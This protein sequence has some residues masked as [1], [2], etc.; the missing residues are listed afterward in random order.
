MT[1]KDGTVQLSNY[2]NNLNSPTDADKKHAILSS[3]KKIAN[4]SYTVGISPSRKCNQLGQWE[5]VTNSCERI[6]CPALD[7]ELPSDAGAYNLDDVITRYSESG[8]VGI[9]STSSSPLVSSPSDKI[10]F[11]AP[12]NSSAPQ[13]KV[14]P[15]STNTEY[16]LLTSNGANINL[17]KDQIYVFEYKAPNYYQLDSSKDSVLKELWKRSGGASFPEGYAIRS[18]N[19]YYMPNSLDLNDQHLVSGECNSQL[20]YISL[21][22]KPTMLCDSLG[23]WTN[24]NNSCVGDCSAVNSVIGND[25]THG[26]AIWQKQSPRVGESVSSSA[27]SCISGTFAYPYSP[28]NDDEGNKKDYGINNINLDITT[29]SYDAIATTTNGADFTIPAGTLPAPS[30]K[31]LQGKS[32]ALK[33]Q[34]NFGSSSAF[35]DSSSGDKIITIF[36][37]SAHTIDAPTDRVWSRINF[38]SYGTPDYSSENNLQQD[39]ENNC[40]FLYTKLVLA[41]KCL[42]KPTCN[43]SL[44]DFLNY[45]SYMPENCQQNFGNGLNGKISTIEEIGSTGGGGGGNSSAESGTI[46]SVTVNGVTSHSLSLSENGRSFCDQNLH[47]NLCNVTLANNGG[48]KVNITEND[49]G[50]FDGQSGYAIIK[51]APTDDTPDESKTVYNYSAP[52]VYTITVPTLAS[53]IGK[54]DIYFY[55]DYEIA[56]GGGGGGGE[57]IAQG[58]D[59]NPGS[60]VSGKFKIEAGKS[61]KVHIGG[62]GKA[63]K[64][65]CFGSSPP[66]GAVSKFEDKYLPNKKFAIAKNQ[67]F[68]KKSE[69]KTYDKIFAKNSHRQIFDD[70]VYYQYFVKSNSN[71]NYKKISKINNLRGFFKFAKYSFKSLVIKKSYAGSCNKAFDGVNYNWA[72]GQVFNYACGS[73]QYGSIKETCNCPANGFAY[74]FEHGSFNGVGVQYGIGEHDLC[75]KGYSDYFS[76]MKLYGDIRVLLNVGCDRWSNE[77]AWGYY[78]GTSG[79]NGF[80]FDNYFHRYNDKISFIGIEDIR[81]CDWTTTGSCT[82]NACGIDD[83]FGISSASSGYNASGSNTGCNKAN[84]SGTFDWYC[85]SNDGKATISRNGCSCVANYHTSGNNCVINTCTAGAAQGY[86]GTTTY[87][88]ASGTI[89]CNKTNFDTSKTLSFSACDS[90]G[91]TK[92]TTGGTCTCATGY[93]LSGSGTTATC[94]RIKCNAPAQTG[95]SGSSTIDYNTSTTAQNCNGT[96]FNTSNQITFSACTTNGSNLTVSSG[97]CGCASGYYLSGSGTTATCPRIKCNAPAQAGYSGSSTIDY[98]TSTTAQNCDGTNFNTSN[99]IIFSACTANNSN[100]TVSSGSCGC[101]S[102]YTLSGT[103]ASATC[104]QNCNRKDSSSTYT[105]TANFGFTISSTDTTVVAGNGGTTTIACS[106]TGYATGT[107]NATLTCNSGALT[108]TTSCSCASGYHKISGKCVLATCTLPAQT[109]FASETISSSSNFTSGSISKSC[110]NNYTGTLNF[111]C[112]HPPTATTQ[113][114]T[115]TSGTCTCP[116]GF[117]TSGSGVTQSCSAITCSASARSGYTGSSTI[118]YTSSNTSINCN[119]TNF[120]NTNILTYDSCNSNGKT[121]TY[122]SGTC[123]CSSGY[124]L[125]TNATPSNNSCIANC[126]LAANDITK[127]GLPSTTS[128][129]LSALSTSIACKN[130]DGYLNNNATIGCDGNTTSTS[131][132]L[133]TNCNCDTTNNFHHPGTVT[134][135]SVPTGSWDINNSCFKKCT[136]S[137]NLSEAFG[138]GTSSYDVYEGK[139]RKNCTGTRY[140]A[141]NASGGANQSSVVCTRGATVSAVGTLSI[142]SSSESCPCATG[143]T[144]VN[145]GNEHTIPTGTSFFKGNDGSCFKICSIS[146]NDSNGIG[147]GTNSYQIYEGSNSKS[148]S[149]TGFDTSS[150][151]SISCN[152]SGTA[153]VTTG[154]SCASGYSKSTSSTHTKPSDS[155]TLNYSTGTGGTCYKECVI[156]AGKAHGWGV[157][158][159]GF[160]ALQ[161]INNINCSGARY[162]T[163]ATPNVLAISCSSTGSPTISGG[164]PCATGYS[165]SNGSSG[166]T[167]PL[168]NTTAG[169][170]IEYFYLTPSQANSGTCFKDCSV[171]STQSNTWG[172]GTSAYTVYEGTNTKGCTSNGFVTGNITVNC[173]SSGNATVTTACTKV[174][175]PTSFQ[176]EGVNG[177][178]LNKT[179]QNSIS[180]DA[181]GYHGNLDFYCSNSGSVASYT[182]TTSCLEYACTSSWTPPGISTQISATTGANSLT[183]QS[184]LGYHGTY[185]Y[186]CDVFGNHQETSTCIA[187]SCNLSPDSLGGVHG[188]G[189]LARTGLSGNGS[190]DCDANGYSGTKY[191]SC[192]ASGTVT[193]TGT[194]YAN[195]CN[196]FTNPGVTGSITGKSG[197][198]SNSCTAPGY[199]G[200]LSFYCDDSNQAVILNSCTENVCDI[201]AGTGYSGKT[202][203]SI[204]GSYACD[205]GYYGTVNWVC[206]V[207]GGNATVTQNC[208]RIT[209]DLPN[210][211]YSATITHDFTDDVWTN[212]LCKRGYKRSFDPISGYFVDPQ[213]KCQRDADGANPSDVSIRNACVEVTCYIPGYGNVNYNNSNRHTITCNP[214]EGLFGTAILICDENGTITY[215]RSCDRISC[216]LPSCSGGTCPANIQNSIEDGTRIQFSNNEMILSCKESHF[217]EPCPI[218]MT[219][220]CGSPKVRCT[221]DPI[222]TTASTLGVPIFSGL[223]CQQST[224]AASNDLNSVIDSTTVNWTGATPVSTTCKNGYYSVNP[225]EPPKYT[226]IGSGTNARFTPINPCTAVTCLPGNVF[227]MNRNFQLTWGLNSVVS[228][229]KVGYSGTFEYNCTGSTTPGTFSTVR[230]NCFIRSCNL[231]SNNP[232]TFANYVVNGQNQGGDGGKISA[233]ITYLKGGNGGDSSE[234]VTSGAG[235]GGGSVSFIETLDGRIIVIAGGGGGGNGGGSDPYIIPNQSI[236]PVADTKLHANF[237]GSYLIARMQS[238]PI[239]NSDPEK[240][241]GLIYGKSDLSGRFNL[242]SPNGMFINDI[243][244]SSLGD[245]EANDPNLLNPNSV[246]TPTNIKYG[247]CDSSNSRTISET[248]CVNFESCEITDI[249]ELE[250][251]YPVCSPELTSKNLAVL[252]G[253]GFKRPGIEINGQTKLIMEINY[254]TMTYAPATLEHNKVY[255]FIDYGEFWLKHDYFGD[256]YVA[257]VAGSFDVNSSPIKIKFH[258]TNTTLDPK[259]KIVINSGSG[260]TELIPQ[261]LIKKIYN[262]KPSPI[263]VGYIKEN[264]F[265]ILR[266]NQENLDNQFWEIREFSE[267]SALRNTANELPKRTCMTTQLSENGMLGTVWSPS[268]SYCTNKCPGFNP[269]TK[270]GDDRIGAGA[271]LHYTSDNRNG[272]IVYWD[273]AS[274]GETRILTLST[275]ANPET[276]KLLNKGYP[277]FPR[278]LGSNNAKQFEKENGAQAGSEVFILER[279]CGANGVWSDPKPLCFT[280]GGTETNNPIGNFNNT[281]VYLN[282]SSHLEGSVYNNSAQNKRYIQADQGNASTAIGEC[283]SGYSRITKLTNGLY[284]TTGNIETQLEPKLTFSCHSSSLSVN[285]NQRRMEDLTYLDTL[286]GSD[287]R[288]YCKMSDLVIEA[289]SGIS[290]AGS[291]NL[292]NANTLLIPGKSI[293]LDCKTGFTYTQSYIRPNYLLN[294]INRINKN[295]TINWDTCQMASNGDLKNLRTTKL[296]TD[297]R[298]TD[299]QEKHIDCMNQIIFEWYW[300]WDS[301]TSE[302]KNVSKSGGPRYNNFIDGTQEHKTLIGYYYDFPTVHQNVRQNFDEDS[303]LIANGKTELKKVIANPIRPQ[304]ECN[305]VNSGDQRDTANWSSVDIATDCRIAD[306]CKITKYHGIRF[307]ASQKDISKIAKNRPP[308]LNDIDDRW[309]PLRSFLYT[310]EVNACGSEICLNHGTTIN[311][312]LDTTC[313]H[314]KYGR[315]G[316]TVNWKSAWNVCANQYNAMWDM[317]RKYLKSAS[318]NDGHLSVEWD[319][320]D[321]NPGKSCDGEDGYSGS[322]CD[323]VNRVEEEKKPE[324]KFL[325]YSNDMDF[326]S[327]TDTFSKMRVTTASECSPPPEDYSPPISGFGNF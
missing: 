209:C 195:T 103:G 34:Q 106:G 31:N 187:Y 43:I 53:V 262:N 243:I 87:T 229:N 315:C 327:F 112:I 137:A 316:Y 230:N 178:I 207:N 249:N 271:T 299:I 82:N 196:P 119:G 264:I 95:Y 160:N 272:G 94:E 40:H 252:A 221:F 218:N 17:A 257:T 236:S 251:G 141:T 13:I 76:S 19:Y 220:N 238:S 88:G 66:A 291:S 202:N 280:G 156:S 289:S 138:T 131:Y 148:C 200:I 295:Y 322:G 285:G 211:A 174:G 120:D 25:P 189:F 216:T 235:G 193:S 109:G 22:K 7:F 69:G 102:G 142:A 48:L 250:F 9:I 123:N 317:K 27:T 255:N 8:G 30:E 162:A 179:G 105:N 213:Y 186:Y 192:G 212:Y 70:R 108:L 269:T 52:G 287:C 274:I 305:S 85:S 172:T 135:H 28:P 46:N 55:V 157:G 304:F 247:T 42:G 118:A 113:N 154:C 116:S 101:A 10:T 12:S 171:T 165:K 301:T 60:K 26:F 318:C 232:T 93:Y 224:C 275:R 284:P 99:Q 298:P 115:F 143:F 217:F 51:V 190:V 133:T 300:D 226:C 58:T 98:N 253:Y 307:G 223:P 215:E 292:F 136:V 227:G 198:S 41:L 24:L 91:A 67:N 260:S 14:K 44:S 83:A 324:Q 296:S 45:D 188:I 276:D 205:N 270:V 72:N 297:F 2:I 169:S 145:S 77:G 266:L 125:K 132:S 64:T 75:K 100:L 180:C 201:P 214:S 97:S 314:N 286:S 144:K 265:Y 104:K 219:Q 110:Q 15:T 166:H 228:C 319:F 234:T 65:G 126:T 163:P 233:T 177:A 92:T 50:L 151:A 184:S 90:N 63:G 32:Y 129:T 241:S 130:S 149:G 279:T 273:E 256:I 80:D 117:F 208:T 259:F 175:C 57:A 191:Y 39:T 225:S 111:T 167:K 78:Y 258:R 16:L 323:H 6:K 263:S 278:Y 240:T 47:I 128:T 11:T 36:N 21:G 18:K 79:G 197:V 283:L 267:I 68:A 294:E 147:T 38:A 244:F 309:F 239:Q 293:E 159:T 181:N 248:R 326:S 268:N 210:S 325:G 54:T 29:D 242:T 194:C 134:G 4:T 73:Y 146:A 182:V 121:L 49:T 237:L 312:G 254:A 245:P 74:F 20:G 150:N 183:C 107:N 33:I 153:T 199:S 306:K 59:G 282:H 261:L 114:G 173:D 185:S 84:T 320:E 203:Q 5:D 35:S 140:L 290:K 231:V 122:S 23:N 170:E 321:P 308:G 288:K 176:H 302:Y 86:D 161:G 310:S 1:A 152:I 127:W 158:T 62:G 139:T 246:P 206:N 303:I 61:F 89:S 81:V 155:A 124:F 164:C 71:N 281:R 96:N 313:N 56:G 168:D 222:I 204:A 311:I 3:F 37:D 277:V